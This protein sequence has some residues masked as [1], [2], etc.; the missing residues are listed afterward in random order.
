M[1]S[2]ATSPYPERSSDRDPWILARR[3]ARNVV[4][5]D[6]PYAF[7]VEEEC[8]AAGAIVP[9]ATIFLTNRE[10]PWRCVM[11]DLWRNTL[12]G[13]TPPGAIV[14]QLDHALARLP[15]AR[16]VKLYNAG[17]FFDTR[18]IPA[19]EH[20]AIAERLRGFERVIVECHPSLVGDACER[21]RDRI[22]TE[23]EVAMGLET[24][25]EDVLARLNKRMTL[26][27][28]AAAAE[29]LRRAGVALRSFVL[30]RPPF[31]AEEEAR[32]WAV[33]SCAFAFDVGA[34][35]CS[36]IPTRGGNGA[37]EALAAV[38]EFAPPSLAT[39]ETAF[40]DALALGRG[41]VFADLW[42]L[43]HFARCAECLPSRVERLREMNLRQT[44]LPPIACASCGASPC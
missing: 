19:A 15:A 1:T 27:R 36:V 6:A 20:D 40:A 26:A 25:K 21:F 30:V 31:M 16:Q 35:A 4:D 7:F 43:E 14:R 32:E 17:S 33:R 37:M 5:A 23:L 22:G 44:V 11:C 9:V 10:C 18:A 12:P 39:F 42:D 8:S 38:G 13:D 28:Y 24:V 41:R 34:T 3:G 29:R 2:T